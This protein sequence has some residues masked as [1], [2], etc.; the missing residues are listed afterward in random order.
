MCSES[1]FGLDVPHH[2]V[3][4]CQTWLTKSTLL[5]KHRGWAFHTER[6]E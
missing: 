3:K 1:I 4:G 2:I 6:Q 5:P